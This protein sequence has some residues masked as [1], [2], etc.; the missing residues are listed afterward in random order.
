MQLICMKILGAHSWTFSVL[1]YAL[2]SCARC[3]LVDSTFLRITGDTSLTFCSHAPTHT[4]TVVALTNPVY[5][6]IS[7]QART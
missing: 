5:S 2:S 1:R 7:A 6:S 4:Q 3:V